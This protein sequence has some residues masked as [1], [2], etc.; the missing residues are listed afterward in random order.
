MDHD[1]YMYTLTIELTFT[2]PLEA[3]R[4]LESVAAQLGAPGFKVYQDSQGIVRLKR[5]ELT[6]RGTMRLVA[7]DDIGA[8]EG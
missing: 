5:Y 3:A 4:R 8:D 7:C 2:D 1:G 6:N